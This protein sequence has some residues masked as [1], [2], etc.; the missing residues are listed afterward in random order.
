VQCAQ[1]WFVEPV[2]VFS[3]IVDLSNGR[4]LSVGEIWVSAWY[5]STPY[6]FQQIKKRKSQDNGTYNTGC[7]R[8][9]ACKNF[10]FRM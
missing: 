7:T 9:Y 10:C 8:F 5:L 3:S 2:G 6:Y 1:Q 4:K